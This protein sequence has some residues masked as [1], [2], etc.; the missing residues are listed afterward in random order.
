[1]DL[2]TLAEYNAAWTYYFE[3]AKDTILAHAAQVP[4]EKEDA[5]QVWVHLVETHTNLGAIMPAMQQQ[6]E[7]TKCRELD[8]E[9]ERVHIMLMVNYVYPKSTFRAKVDKAMS[10]ILKVVTC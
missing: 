3:T 1:M 6:Y 9:D 10:T 8:P 4:H 5:N 7:L 2:S